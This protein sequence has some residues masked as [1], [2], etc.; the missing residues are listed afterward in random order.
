MSI[1]DNSVRLEYHQDA[2]GQWLK[3]ADQFGISKTIIAPSDSFLCVYND[4]GNA[5]IRKALKSN[6]E[7]FLGLAAANPWYGKVAAVDML[8]KCFDE[9]FAGL[10]LHPAR[11]GF[12]LT[13]HLVD[14][15]VEV[16]IKYKKPVFCYTGIPVC[17]EPFQLAELARR[18]PDATFIMGHGAYPDFWYDVESAMKQAS[19]IYLETS[20]QVGGIIHSAAKAVGSHRLLFGSGYPRSATGIELDKINRMNLPSEDSKKIFTDNARQIWRIER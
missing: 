4:E 13:E 10:Y 19:N 8:N 11:Q 20:C 12:R 9:G 16:C 14:P 2:I 6:P 1:I 15:L 5:W 17:C 18:Y 7:H 3:T